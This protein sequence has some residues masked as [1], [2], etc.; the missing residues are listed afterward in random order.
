MYS[1][2]K[3]SYTPLRNIKTVGA[4][5]ILA[6]EHSYTPL[7]NIKT[8]VVLIVDQFCLG[9]VLLI[10]CK[11][12]LGESYHYCLTL[13]G[14]KVS[15]PYSSVEYTSVPGEQSGC[16]VW[17]VFIAPVSTGEGACKGPVDRVLSP[18]MRCLVSFG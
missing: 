9:R 13:R 17:T 1:A 6:G 18:P 14:V 12:Q 15:Y 16:T 11:S 8:L 7:G 4:T 3:H 5:L 10:R 2:G